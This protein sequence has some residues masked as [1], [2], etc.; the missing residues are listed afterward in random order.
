MN[1]MLGSLV[2]ALG[3]SALFQRAGAARVQVDPFAHRRI[4]HA[5]HLVHCRQCR[6]V[7]G[8]RRTHRCAAPFIPAPPR[9]Y[10]WQNGKLVARCRS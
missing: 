3:I 8:S 10:R 9:G 4:R 1:A 2:A 6:K 5:A 7:V